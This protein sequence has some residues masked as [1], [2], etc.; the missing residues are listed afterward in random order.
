MKNKDKKRGGESGSDL[1]ES[2]RQVLRHP[3]CLLL[4]SAQFLFYLTC[5]Y[6]SGVPLTHGSDK[7]ASILVRKRLMAQFPFAPASKR[8]Y[9]ALDI[10]DNIVVGK[11][12]VLFSD[13]DIEDLGG[14]IRF[15]K[16][17]VS[18]PA[19]PLAAAFFGAFALA[20]GRI[21]ELF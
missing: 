6:I 16:V 7:K 15:L 11:T 4:V 3:F 18:V 17:P 21:L 13:S 1:K 8:H 2:V 12:N 9:V 20:L 19:Y 5:N 10:A 14:R